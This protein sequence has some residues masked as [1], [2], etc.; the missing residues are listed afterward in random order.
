MHRITISLDDPLAE[1][2]DAYLEAT[3][4]R[5]RS[6]GVRDI[7][8]DAMGR[9]NNE[10]VAHKFS[11]ANLSYIYDRRVRR[12]ASRLSE[13]QHAHHDLV[14]SA[15]SVPLDHSSSLESVMLKGSTAALRKFA[16]AV[17]AQRGVRSLNLNLIGVDPGDRHEHPGDHK[18]TGHA[19][20]SPTVS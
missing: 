5:S 1:A 3:G 10:V 8:R 11:V 18:H 13:M 19:H 6:E 9:H 12:L 4:Y 20:L 17:Q 2:L 14:A 15:S 7:V 16:D